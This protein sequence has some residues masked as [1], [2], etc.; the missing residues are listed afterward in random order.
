[1][2]SSFFRYCSQNCSPLKHRLTNSK[3]F[4]ICYRFLRR[5]SHIWAQRAYGL[6]NC[7]VD[8]GLLD[9][10]VIA[11]QVLAPAAARSVARESAEAAR[12]RALESKK[13]RKHVA[14]HAYC[15]YSDLENLCREWIIADCTAPIQAW[16]RTQSAELEAGVARS[17]A[18]LRDQC[19]VGYSK[20]I[21]ETLAVPHGCLNLSRWG[22]DVHFPDGVDTEPGIAAHLQHQRDF[23]GYCGDMALG[24]AESMLVWGLDILA[25]WPKRKCLLESDNLDTALAA[26]REFFEHLTVARRMRD[27]ESNAS[28]TMAEHSHMFLPPCRQLEVLLDADPGV[29]PLC[30]SVV[31]AHNLRV[32]STRMIEEANRAQ[33]GK[34]RLNPVRRLGNDTALHCLNSSGL[35]A[36]HGFSPTLGEFEQGDQDQVISSALFEAHEMNSWEPLKGIKGW[37][38]KTSWY[39]PGPRGVNDSIADLLVAS[40]EGL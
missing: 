23:A 19:S 31:R 13:K 8:L 20:L 5:E 26:K 6:G 9:R 33:S 10:K 15:S 35:I 38:R 14:W 40:R 7:A 39:S 16:H 1:M 2:G 25:G 34:A 30:R 11:D 28:K 37:A 21:N 29:T 36:R 22:V 24:L 18:W 17:A 32:M 3:Y 27:S 4:G 12:K